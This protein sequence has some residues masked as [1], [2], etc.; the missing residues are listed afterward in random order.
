MN[1]AFKEYCYLYYTFPYK[2]KISRFID[3]YFYNSLDKLY[4]YNLI[5]KETK[6]SLEFQK[7]K[8]KLIKNSK[9]YFYLFYLYPVNTNLNLL[10]K[11]IKIYFEYVS[12]F[13]FKLYIINIVIEKKN[14]NLLDILIKY[15]DIDIDETLYDYC[16]DDDIDEFEYFYK[17]NE[18]INL[19]NIEFSYIKHF[20]FIKA[21]LIGWT[22]YVKDNYYAYSNN[23]ELR[24][25][26]NELG[27]SDVYQFLYKKDKEIK[28]N[29]LDNWTFT[30]PF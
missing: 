4:S 14:K 28:K 6:N 29:R 23:N 8:I 9:N 27:H 11:N 7:D 30:P 16:V 5:S 1:L 12:D 15:F 13:D 3:N 19:Y 26:V 21:A 17:E 22:K 25:K 10:N 18:Y 20:M 2:Y 24:D